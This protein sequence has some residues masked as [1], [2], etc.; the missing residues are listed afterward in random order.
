[1]LAKQLRLALSSDQAGEVVAAVHAMRRVLTSSKLDLHTLAG[2]IENHFDEN[3]MTAA[4]QTGL[5]D[6]RV[7][8]AKDNSV[9]SNGG[10]GGDFQSVG[11]WREMWK[12]CQER[13][14]SHHLKAKDRSLLDT[15]ERWHGKPSPGQM[16]WLEDIYERVAR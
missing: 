4:Y 13:R 6:G 15:L 14:S 16:A 3:E 7:A 10:G 8:A 9:S 1:M 11:D 2:V 5:H 12:F